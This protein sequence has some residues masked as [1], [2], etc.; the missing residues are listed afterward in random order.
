MTQPYLYEILIRGTSS[1]IAG[2][3][4]VYAAD[5]VNA[6]TGETRTDVGAAQPVI[7]QDPLNAILGEVTVK[8]IQENDA[9][10][11][12]V[13]RLN[14]ELLARS[15]ELEAMQLALTEAQAQLAGNP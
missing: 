3:H 11:A 4:V 8:A 2:A 12:T 6:L 13:S 15:S 1:G 5:S 7:L 10:K 9:L 14:D